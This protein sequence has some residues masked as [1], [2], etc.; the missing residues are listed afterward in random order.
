MTT[1][2]LLS[3]LVCLTLVAPLA[4]RAADEKADK[5]ASGKK[6]AA[7]AKADAD[8]KADDA[9]LKGRLPAGYSKIVD[10]TQRQKIYGIQAKYASKIDDLQKQLQDLTAKRDSEIRGVLTADQQKKLDEATGDTSKAKSMKKAATDSKGTDSKK[11]S[12]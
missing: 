9:K 2:F 7:A 8:D 11:S 10:D 1:R 6:S 4:L 3:S 12:T 5:G